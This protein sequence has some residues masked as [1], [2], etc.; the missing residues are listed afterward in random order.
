MQ[1]ERY[2]LVFRGEVL[3]DQHPSVVKKRLKELLKIDDE[4][5]A[6]LFSGKAVVLRN[7][8]DTRTAARFQTAFKKSGARLRVLPLSGS[9]GNPALN[10]AAEPEK[11][12]KKKETLA[13]R[14]ARES[15][16]LPVEEEAKPSERPRPKPEVVERARPELVASKAAA[17]AASQTDTPWA[18]ASQTDT[19]ASQTDILTDET[20][21]TDEAGAFT[22]RPVG[23]DVL[24]STERA[25]AAEVDIDTSHLEVTEPDTSASES[26][27]E[28]IREVDVSHLTLAELGATLGQPAPAVEPLLVDIDFEIMAPGSP[29]GVEGGSVLEPAL[30]F[31]DVDF[32]LAE[33][34]AIIGRNPMELPAP[35]PPPD[36]SHLSLEEI[37]EEA[38]EEE[39]SEEEASEG[40]GDE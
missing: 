7:D 33:V 15:G 30:D 38:T 12:P 19:D 29:L 13:E 31:T 27:S 36:T 6:A 4:R 26:A 1:E 23:S 25:P 5:A 8:A 28:S 16:P 18:D 11:P 9:A 3:A 10:K 39:A 21:E 20:A 37:V 40:A 14:L 24:D 22:V 32:S 2:R 17:A 35:P 34:G